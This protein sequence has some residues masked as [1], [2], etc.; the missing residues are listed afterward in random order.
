[1]YVLVLL[2]CLYCS[3]LRCVAGRVLCRVVSV[4]LLRAV[5]FPVACLLGGEKKEVTSIAV[6]IN[7]YMYICVCNRT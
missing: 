6:P 2:V 1:M 5:V 4:L 7:I 3:V